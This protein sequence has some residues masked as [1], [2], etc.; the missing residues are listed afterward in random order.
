[1]LHREFIPF[2]PL[3][4][5]KPE[6]PLDPPL[7]P[8]DRFHVPQG[9]WE[10]STK[11][12]FASARNLMDLVRTCHEWNVLPETPMA[13]FAIYNVAF[14]GMTNQEQLIFKP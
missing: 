4:C 14:V 8:P 11:E 1:M 12:L 2:V 13:G 5:S 7:F 10:E 9:F 3:R 6:G